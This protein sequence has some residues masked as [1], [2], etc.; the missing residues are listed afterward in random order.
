MFWFYPVLHDFVGYIW[1]CIYPVLPLFGYV[2]LN[3]SVCI[4]SAEIALRLPMFRSLCC[5]PESALRLPMFGSL[6]CLPALR[7]PLFGSLCCLPESALRLPLFGSL[8][9]LPE[10]ILRL[11]L[12]FDPSV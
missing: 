8:S 12:D 2:C 10:S 6:Y 9:C 11:P 1:L 7:L 3:L 4:C 5:L